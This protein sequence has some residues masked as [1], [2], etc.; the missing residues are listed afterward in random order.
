MFC[1]DN[2]K[3]GETEEEKRNGEYSCIK[4]GYL[5]WSNINFQKQSKCQIFSWRCSA[6]LH[7]ARVSLCQRS[8]AAYLSQTAHAYARH[9]RHGDS[10]RRERNI[11]VKHKKGYSLLAYA[12]RAAHQ[13]QETKYSKIEN[14]I[15]CLNHCVYGMQY[16]AR[17]I[18]FLFEKKETKFFSPL[19]PFGSLLLLR[20]RDFI[21]FAFVRQSVS[22]NGREGG[23]MQHLSCPSEQ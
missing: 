3:K 16:C 6:R 15:V 11:L 2:S 8:P 22:E 17:Q 14:K 13:V 18:E 12:E 21:F 5:F 23:R 10:S 1:V 7:S 9:K 20:C 4:N 19:K